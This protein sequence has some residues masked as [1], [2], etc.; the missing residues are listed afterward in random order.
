MMAVWVSAF[1]ISA[2]VGL[3][4]GL[5]ENWARGD[6]IPNTRIIA[7][8]MIAAVVGG[9][10]PVAIFGRFIP[11]TPI[12]LSVVALMVDRAAADASRGL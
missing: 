9:M 5:L 6:A 4:A 12:I 1:V 3:V 11:Y 7:V 2:A 8:G 10:A